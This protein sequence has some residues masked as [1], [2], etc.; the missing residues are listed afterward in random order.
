MR[1][2]RFYEHP[3]LAQAH[4]ERRGKP[5]IGGPYHAVI[6]GIDSLGHRFEERVTLRDFSAGG[7]YV[8]AR[9]ALPPGSTLAILVR[10]SPT[11]LDQPVAAPRLS[12][13]GTV[14]RTEAHPD[15]SYGV[16]I[17]FA[18]HRFVYD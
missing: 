12:L 14:A 6:Q 4:C 9:R 16:A 7:L 13:R 11:P 2:N 17:T 8:N 3:L 1:P 18:R 5:R 15:G 10:L